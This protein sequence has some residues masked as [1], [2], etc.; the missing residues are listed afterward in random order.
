MTR[1]M[2]MPNEMKDGLAAARAR[3]RR[4][5]IILFT[6]MGL[7]AVVGFFSAMFEVDGGEFLEGIPAAWAIAA[8]L[9]T[10]IG[11]A[12]GGWRYHRVTDELERRD[13]LWA[14]AIALNFYLA[15]YANWYLWWRGGLVREPQ[16]E[17]LAVATFAVMLL[18]YGYKKLRP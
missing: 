11:I 16:H 15:L 13:N 10:T 14:S 7:G 8:S 18:A 1:S 5:R 9:L 6:L 2:T 17:A 4:Q 3:T 12:Y